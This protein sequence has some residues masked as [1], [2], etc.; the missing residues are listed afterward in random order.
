[1]VVSYTAKRSIMS[2]HT[3][4]TVYDLEFAASV[5][6][7][8]RDTEKKTNIAKSGATVTLLHRIDKLIEVKSAIVA[9]AE[10]PAWEEFIDS[11]LGGES[12]SIDP[13][14]TVAV[15]DQPRSVILEGQVSEEREG[16]GMRWR[17]G[18]KVRQL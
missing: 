16:T 2:G 5:I 4:G 11:V 15:P 7:H 18:F 17:F 3:A 14:G 6:N 13:Y 1:M 9:Q 10:R 8:A 12:F